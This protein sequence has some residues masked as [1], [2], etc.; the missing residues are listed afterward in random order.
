MPVKHDLGCTHMYETRTYLICKLEL[1]SVL[2]DVPKSY[3][4]SC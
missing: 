2:V 3:Q 1:E 4:A